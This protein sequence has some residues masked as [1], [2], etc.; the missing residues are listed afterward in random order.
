MVGR[1]SGSGLV[2]IRYV[3]GEKMQLDLMSSEHIVPRNVEYPLTGRVYTSNGE[4]VSDDVGMD[5]MGECGGNRLSCELFNAIEMRFEMGYQG[6]CCRVNAGVPY[7]VIRVAPTSRDED[8]RIPPGLI[9]KR[10]ILRLGDELF[11]IAVIDR[12]MPWL[13]CYVRRYDA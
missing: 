7:R 12:V 3:K 10:G 13:E 9:E 2:V 4:L 5:D 6:S 8:V 11:E 1:R